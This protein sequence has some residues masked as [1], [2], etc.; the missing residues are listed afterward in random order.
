MLSFLRSKLKNGWMSVS[1]S[2]DTVALAHVRRRRDKKPQVRFLYSGPGKI[3]DLNGLR[4]LAKTH[5]LSRFR[6][7][8]LLRPGE[9]QLL[10][11]EAP[12]VAAEELK[13]ALRWRI[14]DM[15]SYPV[16]EV[17]LD[18]LQIPAD[19]GAASRA[20]QAFA[21]AA[22]NG[23][24]A[25]RVEL[26]DQANLPLVAIDIPE[27]AQRN[28]SALFEEEN[29]GLALLAFDEGGGMLTFTFRGELCAVRS[30]DI[31]LSQLEEAEG[32][33]LQQYL[34]RIALEAQRSL[35]NFDRLYGHI[36]VPRLLVAP[37]PGVP[38]FLEQLKRDISLPIEELDLAEVLDFPEFPQ[39]SEPRFQTRFLK[40][41]GA[42]LRE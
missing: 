40:A 11:V 20:K 38:G 42:A 4:A 27:L 22:H 9:Y 31:P 25:P 23:L 29:R 21:V 26:F 6:S 16:D 14:K 1:F 15:L 35:D 30:T 37:L 28:I 19:P 17:T 36:T 39:L 33:R 12:E 10:Q 41:L 32:D 8:L 24:L 3:D 18:A 13:D 7:S 2:S 5:G 34:E